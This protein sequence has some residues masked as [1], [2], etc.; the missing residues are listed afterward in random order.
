MINESRRGLRRLVGRFPRVRVVVVG[1]LMLDRFVWGS[2]R[3]ISPEAPVPVVHVRNEDACPGGAGNVVTN[4]SALGGRVAVCGVVGQD[5][6]GRRLMAALREHGADTSGV[7]RRRGVETIQ[8]TRI[9]A[10][11]QQ[12]VRLDRERPGPLER[13]TR[14]ALREWTIG[15]IRRCD[16]VVL[17]DYGKGVVDAELLDALAEA[18]RT[19]P[20]TWIV[21][22][23][24]A[25]FDHYRLAT[26]VKPNVDEAAAAA[27]MSIPNRRA[28]TQAGR[29]LLSRWETEAVLI[30]QGEEGMTLFRRN[31]RPRAFPTVARA[32]F[33]VTGAGD[34]VIATCA[35]ALGAGG[36]PE[37][38]TM[39]AN[40]AAGL[41]V[42]K[43]GT[44]PVSR[45]ELLRAIGRT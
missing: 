29:R 38:A 35:L 40:Q 6:A 10:N 41:A 12:V 19:R 2:V 23:K 39:L 4:V 24:Q 9:I 28:L 21:D 1:D 31:G 37:E 18:H 33:D 15:R 42:A 32:V 27:G 22:P 8:K 43:V 3:R 11:H 14:Q 13:R 20:F 5:D 34:T 45:A 17:S 7:L 25:N 16:V 26:L 36:S 30:S 44:A